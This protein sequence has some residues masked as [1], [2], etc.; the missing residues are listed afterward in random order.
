MSRSLSPDR[1][2]HGATIWR[3]SRTNRWQNCLCEIVELRVNRVRCKRGASAFRAEEQAEA[4]EERAVWETVGRRIAEIVPEDKAVY[5]GA[6]GTEGIAHF[7]TERR[8]VTERW[9]SEEEETP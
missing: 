8:I 2:I 4:V 9:W 7:F 3:S 5:V 1:M 6:G